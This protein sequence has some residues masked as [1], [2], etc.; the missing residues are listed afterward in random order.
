MSGRIALVVNPL[1]GRNRAGRELPTLTNALDEAG[2]EYEVRTTEHTRHATELARAAATAGS[3]TVVAV[4]GDGTVN[5]VVNGLMELE[6]KD[7]PALGVVAAGSGADFARSFDLPQ[8]TNDGLRGVIGDTRPVDVGRIESLS[9]DGPAVRHFVN[10]AN[11]GLAAS[12]VER[13]ERLPRRLGKARYIVAF[14]PALARYRPSRVVLTVDGTTHAERA[15]N[16]LVANGRFAGG[17]MHFSPHSNPSDGVFDIQ[18]NVGP[19]RQSFTLIPRIYRGRH[20][21][22]DRIIQMSGATITIEPETAAPVEADGELIGT[23]PVRITVLPAALN[24]VVGD[25]WPRE[26]T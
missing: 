6:H 16:V 11:V 18:M 7:R 23:S 1:A 13:A 19:K 3:K 8:H 25:Q 5:E 22:N 12:T 26:M 2:V 4:G 24:L 10:I 17:G 20:L 21:P 9:G 15:H 14:W